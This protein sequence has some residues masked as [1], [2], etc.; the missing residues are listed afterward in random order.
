MVIQHNLLAMNS[1]RSL[2]INTRKQAKKTEK[3]S[4]GYRVNRAADDAAGL[5]ISEKMRRQIRG[6][7]Q[8]SMNCQDGISMVQTADG[9]LAEVQ[10]MLDRCTELSVKAANG[11]LTE[12]DRSYIQREI[13][14]L[15]S[16]MDEVADRTTFNELPIL[17]GARA[18]S[19]SDVYAAEVKGGLPSWVQ[20]GSS[21]ASGKLSDKIATSIGD[22]LG[23]ALDFSAIDSD[24][25]K[26]NDLKDDDCGFYTT[27]CTCGSHYSIKFVD[28]PAAG[29]VRS[30]SHNIFE[31]SLDG[32]SSASDLVNA[33]VDS[34][35]N[36]PNGH[37]TKLEAD[38]NKLL[39]YDY[40]S[41]YTPGTGNSVPPQGY[42]LA[43]SGVAYGASAAEEE[44]LPDIVIHAGPEAG[45]GIPI[46]L[47][48]ISCVAM[49]IDE[50]NVS[51]Q[52]YA[53]SSINLFKNAKAYVS[54][55]RARMGA[56]QN[57]ME[58]A[59][60]NLNNVSENTTASESEIRDSDMATE[61][62][63]Y[64]NNNIL[65]QAGQAMLSQANQ[66]SQG[67]MSLLG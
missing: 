34:V 50:A 16:E 55:E 11:T 23:M 14:E 59:I 9:A 64:S 45:D 4:S 54:E 56:Y 49:G 7:N 10:E 20:G 58:H 32:V 62:V 24:P 36:N 15:L 51:D 17:K 39:V 2:G 60:A 30:G 13:S 28:G 65:I 43:G 67:I 27:C 18:V 8:A 25:T 12:E 41:Q 26:L 35:G 31:V 5:A 47:P 29:P 48:S 40:R 38:G 1:N 19:T 61:M 33:I 42:G 66:S 37:Y 22:R 44:I 46:K 52:D 53:S 21:L 6:L 57:R 3:L 63:E